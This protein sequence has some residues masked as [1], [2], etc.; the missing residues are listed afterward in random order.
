MMAL[1]LL[2]LAVVA[3][4]LVIGLALPLP[5]AGRAEGVRQFETLTVGRG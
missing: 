1:R 3:L 2:F 5:H 4:A